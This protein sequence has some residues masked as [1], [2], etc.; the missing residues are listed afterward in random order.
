MTCPV[1][2]GNSHTHSHHPHPGRQPDAPGPQTPRGARRDASPIPRGTPRAF[3]R[4]GSRATRPS[5]AQ[6]EKTQ[7]RLL[8]C[9]NGNYLAVALYFFASSGSCQSHSGS[10]LAVAAILASHPRKS[11]QRTLEFAAGSAADIGNVPEQAYLVPVP[12]RLY[13]FTLR[14]AGI[15]LTLRTSPRAQHLRYDG[16]ASRVGKASSARGK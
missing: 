6:R 8:G 5:T 1:P 16:N 12:R 13:G 2:A 15:G 9:N 14:D 7:L 3:R 11:W 10:G 4:R